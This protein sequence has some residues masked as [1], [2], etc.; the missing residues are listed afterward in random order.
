MP[1]SAAIV[2]LTVGAITTMIVAVMTRATLGHTGRVLTAGPAT[3][4]LYI[5]GGLAALARIGAAFAG[6]ASMALLIASA[7]CWIAA[8]AL[9]GIVY[10]RMLVSAALRKAGT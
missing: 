4:A 3:I 9:F 1:V 2:T 10:G 8:F 6:A 7:T 5:L